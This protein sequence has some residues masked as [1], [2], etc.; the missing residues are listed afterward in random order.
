MRGSGTR[1]SGTSAT[2]EDALTASLMHST[3][4]TPS[5]KVERRANHL[6]HPHARALTNAKPAS[7][8]KLWRNP[9]APPDK[10]VKA[11]PPM[12][13]ACRAHNQLWPHA[14]HLQAHL[15]VGVLPLLLTPRSWCPSPRRAIEW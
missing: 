1:P 11:N 10:T 6:P 7:S 2:F 14:G 15:H 8:T 4:L 3:L 5:R 13:Q 9:N 12:V